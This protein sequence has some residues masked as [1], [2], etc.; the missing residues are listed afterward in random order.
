MRIRCL[1]GSHRWSYG[2]CWAF[3]RTRIPYLILNV[4]RSCTCGKSQAFVSGSVA[5][6]INW[7]AGEYPPAAKLRLAYLHAHIHEIEA[8]HGV[9]MEGL[10]S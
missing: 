9:M 8:D 3:R 4:Y 5:R 10:A 1:L 2:S 6:W 7:G